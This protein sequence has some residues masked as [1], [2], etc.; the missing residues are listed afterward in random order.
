MTVG[1][2]EA[3]E[4]ALA[5]PTRINSINAVLD[6]LGIEPHVY[7]ISEI[8]QLSTLSR[9]TVTRILNDLID[10][11]LVHSETAKRSHASGGRKPR[12]YSLNLAHHCSIVLRVRSDVVEGYALDTAGG[13]ITSASTDFSNGNEVPIC[14]SNVLRKILGSVNSPVYSTAAV[15]MGIVDHG[16]VVRSESFPVLND[17]AWLSNLNQILA[18]HGHRSKTVAL[19]D[20]KVAAQWM[21]GQLSVQDDALDSM[22]AIHLSEDI[23]CGLI[24]GG[25]LIEGAHGA[26][27]E[28]LQDRDS[29][30]SITS[31]Y[32]HELEDTHGV[33]LRE[34]FAN[35][36]HYD[37]EKPFVS[38][39]GTLMGKA[40]SSMTLT[41]DPHTIAIGGAIVDCGEPLLSA[42]KGE[43]SAATPT[44]PDV[45]IAPKGVQSVSEGA[46]MHVLSEARRITIELL[47][48]SVIE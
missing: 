5:S 18:D 10:E 25:A 38:K 35:W 19:N 6:V 21:Y 34:L 33:S 41:L 11:D 27:G 3:G 36:Q 39:L 22:I 40:L 9:P 17:N 29:E 31:K 2:R 4:S 1:L 12:K 14:F 7:S 37:N 8:C 45:R 47:T 28:I 43:L 44:P 42:I 26:A 32:L 48:D 23:G 30:W 16:K 20:A 24:F 46:K 13:A 15:V